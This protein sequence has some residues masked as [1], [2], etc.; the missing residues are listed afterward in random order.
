MATLEIRNR[1]VHDPVADLPIVDAYMRWA[2]LAAEEVVGK[3]GLSAI[4]RQIS[5]AHLI[6]NYP[7]ELLQVSGNL[8]YGDYANLNCGLLEFFGRAGKSMTMR[9]GRISA[10]HGIEQQSEIFGIA[11]LIASKILPLPTQIKK[12]LESM[13]N[14]YRRLMPNVRLS[15]EDRGDK[16]AYI[17]ET[18]S[19]CADK[20]ANGH[21]CW[22]FGGVLQGLLTWQTGKELEIEEVQCRAQGAPTCVWE[23]GKKARL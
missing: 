20:E 5:L 21:I 3:P 17:T 11:V 2:L 22:T 1:A 19:F 6:D 10:R 13:Q 18:C 15:L 7:P 12:G 4:L 23:I 9:V 14:G 16:I 8:R